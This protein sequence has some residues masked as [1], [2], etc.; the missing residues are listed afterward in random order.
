[1]MSIDTV[2]DE[3]MAVYSSNKHHARPRYC[4]LCHGSSIGSRL[5]PNAL[6]T[7]P[8]LIRQFVWAD[9]RSRADAV[10]VKA[11]TA[12]PHVRVLGIA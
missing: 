8:K 3:R 12:D 11:Q 10:L 2:L 1:M 9:D 4:G 7:R 5:S 6:N